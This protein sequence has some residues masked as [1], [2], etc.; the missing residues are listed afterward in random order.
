VLQTLNRLLQERFE[1]YVAKNGG[2]GSTSETNA[3]EAVSA[4]YRHAAALNAHA[5]VA[6]AHSGQI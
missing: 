6:G 3:R 1:D 2:R 5:V 4:A